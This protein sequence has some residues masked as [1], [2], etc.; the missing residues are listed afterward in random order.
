MTTYAV[1]KVRKESS[2]SGN[3]RHEHIE[4]VC[5]TAGVHYIRKEVVDSLEAGDTWQTLA[6]GDRAT[7]HKITYCP[8]SGCLATPYIRTGADATIANNLENL[9]RC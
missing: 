7:I 8:A 5:S 4:G 9:P 2:G 1:T 6:D 3:Q